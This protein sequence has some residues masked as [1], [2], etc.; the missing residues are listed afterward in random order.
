MDPTVETIHIF[1]FSSWFLADGKK[2]DTIFWQNHEVV[3]RE[4]EPFDRRFP[5][6]VSFMPVF[7][8]LGLEVDDS[9][10]ERVDTN[11]LIAYND[12]TFQLLCDWT[13]FRHD[14]HITVTNIQLCRP[15]DKILI[16]LSVG[17]INVY[18]NKIVT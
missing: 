3:G 11:A 2:I 4:Q 14:G 15:I 12:W 8:K 18:L 13:N 5:E 6:L 9:N 1:D 7:D 10:I 16:Y 17:I